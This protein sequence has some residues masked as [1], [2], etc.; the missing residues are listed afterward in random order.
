MKTNEELLKRKEELLKEINDIDKSIEKNNIEGEIQLT[1]DRINKKYLNRNG[2]GYH[3]RLMNV[4]IDERVAHIFSERDNL[5]KILIHSQSPYSNVLE[6]L[7]DI[8][9]RYSSKLMQQKIDTSAEL[10]RMDY[11]I[12]HRSA[13][14][15][16]DIMFFSTH[17]ILK[18]FNGRPVKS[19]NTNYYISFE[20]DGTMT[21]DAII[22]YTTVYSAAMINSSSNE[23]KSVNSELIKG[24]FS[25]SIHVIN[26]IP[27][28]DMSF[29]DEFRIEGIENFDINNLDEYNK[30]L[31]KLTENDDCDFYRIK[32]DN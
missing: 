3:L 11:R 27:H 23:Y 18:E 1:V 19:V 9:E 2:D 30:E 6:L 21:A 10:R 26:H 32:K 5:N 15:M 12:D 28:G 13:L 4:D 29:T 14:S 8:E 7:K 25:R 22:K 31:L 16:L 17:K 20:D 24:T